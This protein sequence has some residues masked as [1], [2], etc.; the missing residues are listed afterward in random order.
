MKFGV[1]LGKSATE[2]FAMLNAAYGDVAMKRTTYFKWHERFESGRES[3][4]DD[5]RQLTTYT[6]TKSTRWCA[7]IDV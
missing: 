6:L 2:T 7:Q 3:I 4:D 5:E 1:K